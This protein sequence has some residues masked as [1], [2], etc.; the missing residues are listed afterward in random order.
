MSII[1]HNNYTNVKEV[2]KEINSLKHPKKI[3]EDE[4]IIYN[5]ENILE[6]YF[7]NISVGKFPKYNIIKLP[8]NTLLIQISLAG[9]DKKHLSIIM[10]THTLYIEGSPY[11]KDAIYL[12]KGISTKRFIIKIQLQHNVQLLTDQVS[13]SNGILSIYFIKLNTQGKKYYIDIK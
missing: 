4:Y 3:K 7:I 9:Y 8:N 12:Y 6:Q 13:M 2:N 10:N 11:D 5:S 1:E